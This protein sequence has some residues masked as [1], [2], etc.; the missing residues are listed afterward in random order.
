MMGLAVVASLSRGGM[1]SLIA[2]LM[3]VVA[4][5]FK[6]SP[7]SKPSSILEGRS[8]EREGRS[9]G[10]GASRRGDGEN[11]YPPFGAFSPY[12]LIYRKR[13]RLPYAAPRIGAVIVMLFTV[14]AGIWWVGADP[15]IRRFERSDVASGG[16]EAGRH[17]ETFY[18]SRGWIWRD[19]ASMIRDKWASG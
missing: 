12:L 9:G 4:F 3:F 1:I 18:Q 15:V 17:G 13:L 7:S 8:E 2:G 14:G 10:A 16:A 6:S 5:G 11:D 19:T